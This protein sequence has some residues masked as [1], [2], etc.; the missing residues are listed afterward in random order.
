MVAAE[1]LL[2]RTKDEL[3][4]LLVHA[5]VAMRDSKIVGFAAVEIYSKKLAEIQCLA[6]DENFRR[7]GIG[8]ALVKLCVARAAEHGVIELMAISAS[9]EMFK[10]CG[11]DYSLPNQKRALFIQP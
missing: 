6:V 3:K 5:F 1:Y 7:Q 8:R 11:F 2:P 9:D 4:R 10:S